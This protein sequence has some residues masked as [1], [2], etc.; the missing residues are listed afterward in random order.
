L[1]VWITDAIACASLFG[2]GYLAIWLCAG[3][4]WL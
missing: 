1:K 4:G 3:F 2:G